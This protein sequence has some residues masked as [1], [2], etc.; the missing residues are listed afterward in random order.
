VLFTP[1]WWAWPSPD[2][3]LVAQAAIV[4]LGALPVFWLGRRWLEDDRLAVVGAAAYLLY[5]PLLYATLFDFH[6]VTLAAPLLLFC[7]WAA[8]EGRWW[9]L[10]L[11]GTLAALTQ[12]QVGLALVMLAL[13][14]AVRHPERRRAAALMAAAAAAWVAVAVA[15]IIPAFAV[16][17]GN[18]HVRRYEELGNGPLDILRNLVT[19]PW[20]AAEVLVSGNRLAYLAA[21]LLPLLM[22]PLLAPLLAAGALPQLLINLLASTGPA[23]DI[24]YHYAAVVTPFFV[25]AAVLGLARLRRVRRPALLARLLASPGRLAAAAGVA[26]LASWLILGPVPWREAAHNRFGE[27]AHTRALDRAVALVPGG[28]RVS[29]SNG[30]GGHLSDRRTI[31]L[32]PRLFDAEWVLAEDPAFALAP[33]EGRR[34]LL[35]RAYAARLRT[36][37]RSPAWR[38]VFRRDGVALFRRVGA[39]PQ[40][41][42][43][44]A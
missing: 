43:A 29:A 2:G 12:E 26:A 30:P 20:D 6:P 28:A 10:A 40:G 36:V 1:L 25:A 44:P 42:E 16:E 27:D 33:A 13:W 19:R 18:P 22:L 34:T 38:L 17:G 35:T 3:L 39:I 41:E 8:E 7:I 4:A 15:V 5:P 11:C 23:Q 24:Q 31:Y 9:V 21:L 37:E 14:L 32:F